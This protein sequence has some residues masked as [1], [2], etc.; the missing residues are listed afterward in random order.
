[1]I[2]SGKQLVKTYRHIPPAS[3]FCEIKKI[4]TPPISKCPKGWSPELQKELDKR[5]KNQYNIFKILK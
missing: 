3:Y 4:P 1:M 5:Q 2:E